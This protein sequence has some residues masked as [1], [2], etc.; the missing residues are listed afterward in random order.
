[1]FHIIVT[2][3]KTKLD[4]LLKLIVI[5]NYFHYQNKTLIVKVSV[6][7][8]LSQKGEACCIK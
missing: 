1:M 8:F 7:S 2:K 5:L 3:A 6:I 4:L